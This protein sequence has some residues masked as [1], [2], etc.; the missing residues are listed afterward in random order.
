MTFLY[1]ILASFPH[2]LNEE[3]SNIM[4]DPKF[5]KLVLKGAKD[6]RYGMTDDA[7]LERAFNEIYPAWMED[8]ERRGNFKGESIILYRG[9]SADASSQI[10]MNGL[11][12]SWTWDKKKADNY[13]DTN[14]KKNLFVVEAE[15]PIA[16]INLTATL[17]KIVWPGYTFEE[18][19]RE[20]ELKKGSTISIVSITDRKTGKSY[21]DK[22]VKGTV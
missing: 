17:D 2:Q 16:A 13:S 7:M 8:L 19:E 21:L 9:V 3:F 11:G 14:T 10:K 15:V 20:L 22:E 6:Y 12:V 5:Q 4:S 18:S 1:R